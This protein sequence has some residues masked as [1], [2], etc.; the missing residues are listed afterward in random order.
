[1]VYIP[2]KKGGFFDSR[3]V[4]APAPVKKADVLTIAPLASLSWGAIVL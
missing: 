1:M 3:D 4:R 2:V